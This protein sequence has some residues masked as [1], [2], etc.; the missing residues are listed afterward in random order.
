MAAGAP[1]A[2]IAARRAEAAALAGDVADALRLADEVVAH[3]AGDERERAL[4]VVAALLPGRG[5]WRRSAAAY[6]EL[7]AQTRSGS[8]AGG[9]RRHRAGD[10]PVDDEPGGFQLRLLAVDG[11]GHGS[12]QIQLSQMQGR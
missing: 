5:F 10:L 4:S 2:A 11:A 7:D 9:E 3:P 6:T 12:G 1:A 8:G